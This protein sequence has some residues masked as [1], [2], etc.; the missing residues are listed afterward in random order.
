MLK[1]DL[2]IT[3]R[4]ENNALYH[5]L[6]RTIERNECEEISNQCE[7]NCHNIA[8]SYNCSCNTGYTLNSDGHAC[9]GTQRLTTPTVVA[10]YNECMQISM[11]VIQ[12]PPMT[13]NTPASI[14]LDLTHVNAILDL[15]WILMEELVQVSLTDSVDW[16][17]QH[18]RWHQ[19]SL[20]FI[21]FHTDINEC[22]E[23]SLC[24]QECT[25]TAGSY[26][27]SCSTGYIL[28]NNGISCA[29]KLLIVFFSWILTHCIPHCRHRWMQPW[30]WQLCPNL[31]WHTGLLLLQLSGWLHTW[32]KWN[33]LQRYISRYIMFTAYLNCWFVYYAV[34][35]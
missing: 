21:L 15:G 19:I 33:Q 30:H 16:S 6:W 17:N 20:L 12:L 4:F 28:S 23:G 32:F 9:D 5:C 25:N 29:S 1:T 27:C 34:C 11:S 22:I 24:E 3:M 7:Q 10:D 13:A 35:S 26:N 8:G 14:L 18:D 31:S 2:I